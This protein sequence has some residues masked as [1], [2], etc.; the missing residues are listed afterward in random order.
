MPKEFVL[1]INKKK[2]ALDSKVTSRLTQCRSI[3]YL[4]C[5]MKVSR[6]AVEKKKIKFVYLSSVLK[7]ASKLQK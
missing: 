4:I 6:L 5:Y 1:N 7:K 2:D 3:C